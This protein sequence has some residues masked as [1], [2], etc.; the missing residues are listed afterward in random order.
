MS[1]EYFI[2][3]SNAVLLC[4]QKYLW[5]ACWHFQENINCSIERKEN[6]DFWCFSV[7]FYATKHNINSWQHLYN[8]KDTL[9][10]YLHILI[11]LSKLDPNL[12]R[13]A[14][15]LQKFVQWAKVGIFCEFLRHQLA[16][17]HEWF[18]SSVENFVS[19]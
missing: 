1:T 10:F 3:T 14:K 12:T 19:L 6:D 7:I 15:V 18:F 2:K 13:N 8:S 16:I 4:C 17:K 11:F 9:D 5:R